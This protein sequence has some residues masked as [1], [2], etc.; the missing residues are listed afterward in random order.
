M[1]DRTFKLARPVMRGD[2]IRGFQQDLNFRFG[3]WDIGK[4]LEPDGD[5]SRSTRDAAREVGLILAAHASVAARAAGERTNFR[6]REKN[7][8][9]ALD[10]RDV[11]GQAK[12]ILMERLK[13][14]PEDAF[15]IL[16][17]ASQHLN[18]K[19]RDIAHTLTQTG[20]IHGALTP[21]PASAT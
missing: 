5:Y 16:R 8:Q 13:V 3:A 9:Q 11:I 7:L 14:T 21:P 15:D 2:D 12:G 1:P 19:L 10:S 20:E 18:V 6:D 17:R 4:R